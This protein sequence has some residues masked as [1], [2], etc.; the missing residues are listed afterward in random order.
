MAG[1]QSPMLRLVNFS[2]TMRPFPMA[3]VFLF[4]ALS[5]HGVLA[6][7]KTWAGAIG[8]SDDWFLIMSSNWYWVPIGAPGVDGD[9]IINQG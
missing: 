6:I 7:T 8:S 4:L 1:H 5:R 9:V 3:F 2:L